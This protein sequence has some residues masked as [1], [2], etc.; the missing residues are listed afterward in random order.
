M[1]ELVW[2]L[3]FEITVIV[4]VILFALFEW[5][6]TKQIIYGLMVQSKRLAEKR[7]LESG[8]AEQV[9]VTDMA[10]KLLP[11]WITVFITREQ[12]SKLVRWLYLKAKDYLDDGKFNNSIGED[13]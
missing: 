10:M 2:G 1:M 9:W 5:E 3:R 11:R 8:K 7:V 6:K 13:A 4:G 12:M